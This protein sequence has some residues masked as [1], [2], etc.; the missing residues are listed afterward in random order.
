MSSACQS[1][2]L[3][4]DSP[5]VSGLALNTCFFHLD[6]MLCYME[7]RDVEVT[8]IVKQQRKRRLQDSPACGYLRARGHRGEPDSHR[9]DRTAHEVRKVAHDRHGGDVRPAALSEEHLERAETD[10][11]Q[12]D[13]TR[14]RDALRQQNFDAYDADECGRSTTDG[15]A[16]MNAHTRRQRRPG[17]QTLW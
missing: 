11:R 6:V 8:D 2:I 4:S 17:S 1:S 5:R 15:G 10:L 13:K 9:D 14:P 7:M 16:D 3:G 12:P